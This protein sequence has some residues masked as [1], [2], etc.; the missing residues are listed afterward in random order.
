M[1][2]YAVEVPDSSIAGLVGEDVEKLE[3]IRD[4]TDR[5]H[6]GSISWMPTGDFIVGCKGGQ[7]F[8]VN[9]PNKWCMFDFYF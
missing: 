9:F 3:S 2:K 5:M 4:T 1:S 6:P 8:K 7:L